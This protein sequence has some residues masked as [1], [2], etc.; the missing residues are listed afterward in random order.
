M[1]DAAATS[2]AEQQQPT[3][4]PEGGSLPLPIGCGGFLLLGF[5][6]IGLLVWAMIAGGRLS[7][8][9]G[10]HFP[11]Q[12]GWD[13]YLLTSALWGLGIGATGA[14]LV[15]RRHRPHFADP[16]VLLLLCDLGMLF[17]LFWPA[18]ALVLAVF[19]AARARKQRPRYR[20][21]ALAVGLL[22]LVGGCQWGVAGRASQEMH[23][24][25]A[26]TAAA[27]QGTWHNVTGPGRL[28][29]GADGRFTADRIPAALDWG[30]AP[31]PIDAT[32]TW[33]LTRVEGGPVLTFTVAPEASTPGLSPVTHLDVAHYGSSLVLC[34][35]KDDPDAACADG[36]HR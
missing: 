17:A 4:E 10:P 15:V 21:G 35:W 33:A 1:G 6:A 16:L 30:R 11:A 20:L 32:G 2:T 12:L 26:V 3:V 7:A 18:Q 5:A 25:G 29:L 19:G 24:A 14:F 31:D 34:R 27:L 9:L 13:C 22:L 8:V 28:E 36:F 23:G